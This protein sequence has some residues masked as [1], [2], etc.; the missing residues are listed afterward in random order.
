M[1]NS[2]RGGV[3]RMMNQVI[4]ASSALS[5]IASSYQNSS[6]QKQKSCLL[7]AAFNTGVNEVRDTE[8]GPPRTEGVVPLP[9]APQARR[10]R[11]KAQ[12][13]SGGWS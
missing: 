10:E 7:K 8:E 9:V 2:L 12:S 6:I 13:A 5:A 11:G 3:R 1:H 4:Y